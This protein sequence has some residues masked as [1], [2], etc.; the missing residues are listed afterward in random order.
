MRTS[1]TY[2]SEPDVL[3]ERDLACNEPIS[4]AYGVLALAL[5]DRG[6][7]GGCSSDLE[8]FLDAF[9]ELP[10]LLLEVFQQRSLAFL[11]AQCVDYG[12]DAQQL[13]VFQ[14][15][16]KGMCGHEIVRGHT[17]IAEPGRIV[18]TDANVNTQIVVGHCW[19]LQQVVDVPEVLAGEGTRF[20]ADVLFQN[21]GNQVGMLNGLK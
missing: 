19:M 2:S 13:H 17:R 18:G 12:V 16:T 5:F 6:I 20:D 11:R 21:G 15:E 4:T 9:H 7:N 8:F 14:V 10:P 3:I 1:S